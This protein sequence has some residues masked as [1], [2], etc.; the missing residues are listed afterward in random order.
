MNLK[1]LIITEEIL[2]LEVSA[3]QKIILAICAMPK[4]CR[5]SNQQISQ[6]TGTCI[7]TASRDISELEKRGYVCVYKSAAFR[8][9]KI[10]RLAAEGQE[11]DYKINVSCFREVANPTTSENHGSQN[12]FQHRQ[13]VQQDRQNVR[14]QRQIDYHNLK[15]TKN[16]KE[17]KGEVL[18]FTDCGSKNGQT[19]EHKP[20]DE[21]PLTTFIRGLLD[22]EPETDEYE[23]K[24]RNIIR[25][26]LRKGTKLSDQFR[27]F[28]KT[29][30]S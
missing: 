18:K 19:K 27:Q 28:L 21:S 5:L 16:I 2:R 17:S 7:R 8:V 15:N 6:I 25:E 1:Y 14:Q 26:V 11:T 12:V 4:G 20:P 9:V 29:E 3:S 24:K 13:I 30:N 22:C 23:E 10:N